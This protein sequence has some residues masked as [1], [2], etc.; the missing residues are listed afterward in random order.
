[1][2]DLAQMSL[3]VEQA[4]LGGLI[5]DNAQLS[6][7]QHLT[8]N[9]FLHPHHR[10]IFK[11]IT[12]LIE[13]GQP[14]D[15]VT[16]YETQAID[17]RYLSS[18]AENTP[19]A[20]NTWAYAE[21]VKE[22]YLRYQGIEQS[23]RAIEAFSNMTKP[24]AETSQQ[25]VS[26]YE[27]TLIPKRGSSFMFNK[28]NQLAITPQ[29]WLIEYFIESHSLAEVFGAP[30]SGKSL[31]A[32]DMG[33][34]IASGLSWHGRTVKQGAVIYIAGEGLNGLSRRFSAW[35]N[36][37]QVDIHT[38]PFYLSE[39]AAAFYNLS[40]AIEVE[41]S[42]KQI[43]AQDK[44]QPR[45]IVIDTL[46]RNFGSGNENSTDDM[47]L[48]VSHIDKY[49]RNSFNATVLL[50]HHSGH[51]S[52]ERGRGSSALKAAVDTEFSMRKNDAN[53]LTLTCTKMKDAPHPS[54]LSFQIQSIDLGVFDGKGNP[55]NG[56][57]LI[58]SSYTPPAKNTVTLG[59]NQTLALSALKILYQEAR[60]G[61]VE[62]G[63]A[64]F[65]KVTL[66]QWQERLDLPR[67][68]FYELKIALQ[69][70]G[71]IRISGDDVYLVEDGLD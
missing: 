30:E 24:L 26:H 49:L 70:K 22:Y 55:T 13:S 45:L 28:L 19:T 33:L 41:R 56:A 17:V 40:S 54:P 21:R 36:H 32:I 69:E 27:K 35:C 5:I 29:D 37:H 42:I 15:I 43:V 71:L 59:K 11:A 68:R 10:L 46:A 1:M 60:T 2:I 7:V 63:K 16:L 4:V 34:S 38:L 67:Q 64:H 50:V 58:D 48:F 12:D 53:I 44:V 65:A 20:A 3:P 18:L 23:K 14:A 61:L 57:V 52:D 9:D 66:E 8:A 31:L 62:I 39:Q 25:V 47:G 6:V 51:G